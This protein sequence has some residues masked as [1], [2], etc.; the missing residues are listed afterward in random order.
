MPITDTQRNNC[1][2]RLSLACAHPC[3]VRPS[4][5]LTCFLISAHKL[6]PSE[7]WQLSCSSFGGIL[8][9]NKCV[10]LTDPPPRFQVINLSF[11]NRMRQEYKKLVKFTAREIVSG[12]ITA[13]VIDSDYP[14]P[15][16]TCNTPIQKTSACNA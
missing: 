9:S 6:I 11:L 4:Q 2:R 12:Q 14:A 1:D 13:S 3:R 15:A 5:K 16:G 7:E 10:L 8:I